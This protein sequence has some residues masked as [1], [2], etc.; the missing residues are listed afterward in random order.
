MDIYQTELCS[1]DGIGEKRVKLFNKLGVD[2]VG[3]LLEFYPRAYEDWSVCYSVSDAP[4]DTKCCIKALVCTEVNERRIRKGLTIYDFTV[5]DDKSKLQVVIFN[6]KYLAAKAVRDTYILLFGKVTLNSRGKPEMNTP[7]IEPTVNERIRPIYRQTEGLT[8]RAIEKAVADAL[9]MTSDTLYDPISDQ[10]RSK[11]KLCHRRFALKRVH[12]PQSQNDI[13]TARYRLIFEELLVFSLAMARMRKRLRQK[14]AFSL[15]QDYTAE[16]QS[17]LPFEMTKAQKSAV[18]DAARDMSGNEPMNRLLQGDVGSGKTAVAAALM[19]S[20]AKNGFQCAMMAPTE[21]LASQHYASVSSLMQGTG[22]KIMLLSGSAPKKQKLLIYDMVKNGEINILIGT[23][24]LIQSSV[25]FK[26]LALV[27]V[28]EQHRFGVAQR[29]ELAGKG[30]APHIY[31]MS[32]TPIPR[33]LAMIIYGDLD[34]S[35][36]NELPAGRQPIETYSVDFSF[37]KRV[38]NYI[39]KHLNEGRQGYIVCPIID[40]DNSELA[41]AVQYYKKLSENEFKDFRLGMLTGKMKPDEKNKVMSEFQRGEVQ[42]LISTTVIEVGV[43]VANAVIMVIENAER[44]GLSQLHQL[45]GRVGRGA[46]KSTCIL[47]SNADNDAS[48]KR[49]KIMCE[50]SDG[51][52]IADEDLKLRGPGDFFGSRQHGLPEF[53]IAD[54]MSD[55]KVLRQ[56]Q[57]AARDILSGD[58]DLC[59]PCNAG[60]KELVMRMF[61]GQTDI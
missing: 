50:T 37:R 22:L 15:K 49:L 44:F 31:V 58:P 56:A 60:L 9:K 48:R 55:M 38:Y 6:N 47:I 4:L 26:N 1:L 7:Q 24:A 54:I 29:A 35:V 13:S 39:K 19:Y 59:K 16:F 12:F 10:F 18:A 43:D 11:Y 23:H 57:Q 46:H 8:S 33:T 20:C 34:I 45:R 42:L 32:A 17:L 3:A 36:L 41:S 53:K 28:D 14:N 30:H 40:D 27:I 25:E 21:I 2:S 51:F 61:S 52:K 5:C